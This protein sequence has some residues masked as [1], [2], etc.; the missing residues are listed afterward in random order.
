MISMKLS[1]GIVSAAI[2]FMA[3]AMPTP[4]AGQNPDPADLRLTAAA[5]RVD[6]AADNA[7]AQALINQ[8]KEIERQQ[9]KA[10]ADQKAIE[11]AATA[12]QKRLDNLA[13]IAAR[14]T[15]TPIPSPTPIASPTSIATQ[16][17]TPAP[18]Y[19]APIGAAPVS[20]QTI[21]NSAPVGQ[22]PQPQQ[23]NVV[24]VVLIV[25]G[26]IVVIVVV[27]RLLLVQMAKGAQAGRELRRSK[28]EE[29]SEQMERIRRRK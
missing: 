22:Q 14:P 26:L 18:V 7:R 16:T 13:T 8:A 9:A 25:I 4:V 21:G 19:A 29:F 23:P 10:T 20:A 27:F 2:A 5:I 12:E 1:M 17:S 28:M 3:Y 6:T 15:E 11:V 24:A